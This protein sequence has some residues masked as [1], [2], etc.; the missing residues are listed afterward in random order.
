[1]NGSRHSYRFLLFLALIA[2]HSSLARAQ[3]PMGFVPI[4]ACRAVDTRKATGPLGGPLMTGGSTRS[5]PLRSSSCGIPA[6][7]SAYSLNVA[8]LPPGALDFIT[9]WPTGQL[10]PS[11]VTLND[12]GGAVLDNAAIVGAGAN[13]A[14][15]V[16]VTN[17]THIIFDVN[18]YF[19]PQARNA[20][21]EVPSGIVNGRNPI[22]KIANIP[23]AG[24]VPLLA[25]NGLLLKSGVDYT[26]EGSIIIFVQAAV[27]QP[28]DLLQVWYRY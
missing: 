14:I 15:S 1:M 5:F 21:G 6:N 2:S 28:G 9:V 27:P 17:P 16:Y 3:T 11:T 23:A 18:G 24:S 4:S 20:D 25:R 7:A 26:L 8:V 10:R 19:V 12:P 22:F 13:G